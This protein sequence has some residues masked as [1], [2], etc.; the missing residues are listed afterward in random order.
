MKCL[1]PF[2]FLQDVLHSISDKFDV[3]LWRLQLFK[4]VQI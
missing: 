4:L 3:E 2:T 1:Y